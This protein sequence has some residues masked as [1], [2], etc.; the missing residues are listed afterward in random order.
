MVRLGPLSADNMPETVMA[1]AWAC[2][3]VSEVLILVL[4][5]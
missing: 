3:V 2:K 5:V 1:L 4:K